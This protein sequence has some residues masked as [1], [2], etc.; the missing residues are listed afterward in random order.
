MNSS[1]FEETSISNR[2]SFKERAKLPENVKFP[3]WLLCPHCARRIPIMRIFYFN[4]ELSPI[5]ISLKCKCSENPMV[6]TL[7]KYIDICRDKFRER[8]LY[9]KGYCVHCGVMLESIKAKI[10]EKMILATKHLLLNREVELKMFCEDEKH[11]DSK[12]I[13]KAF[14]PR[15]NKVICKYCYNMIKEEYEM[16]KNGK[17][18][19]S[20]RLLKFS[21]LRKKV[22]EVLIHYDSVKGYFSNSTDVIELIDILEK[23]YYKLLLNEILEPNIAI[24]L[25]NLF[26]M[27]SDTE[28]K[29]LPNIF[30]DVILTSKFNFSI[31]MNNK[32]YLPLISDIVIIDKS[33]FILCYESFDSVT[34]RE[35]GRRLEVPY[36]MIQMNEEEDL[37]NV[38]SNNSHSSFRK[39][40]KYQNDK[41]IGIKFEVDDRN[42]FTHS[43][44]LFSTEDEDDEPIQSE[45]KDYY[46]SCLCVYKDHIFTGG[47]QLDVWKICKNS[48]NYCSTVRVEED[49][50]K[51][52]SIIQMNFEDFEIGKKKSFES[53]GSMKITFSMEYKIICGTDKGWLLFVKPSTYTIEQQKELNLFKDKNGKKEHSITCMCAVKSRVVATGGKDGL[54]IIYNYEEI[55]HF[56]TIL[57]GHTMEIVSIEKIPSANEIIS[58]A[59]DKQI[60]IW[61]IESQTKLN[62]FT[63]FTPH[64]EKYLLDSFSLFVENC[65]MYFYVGYNNKEGDNVLEIWKSRMFDNERDKNELGL[66]VQNVVIKSNYY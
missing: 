15:E 7:K 30:F 27:L 8:V 20:N 11:K 58:A 25:I 10:H 44:V 1:I 23:M 6:T 9:K 17:I 5:M 52:T 38:I 43:L 13:A 32:M 63:P 50:G 14:N 21:D 2:S 3:F 39:V 4:A 33:N 64:L 41:F 57:Y 18:N 28:M 31:Q 37:L 35:E 56:A 49:K 61:N 40:I 54:I 51:I 45:E 36:R 19:S 34:K 66:M 47:S 12:I 48:I 24:S 59:K 62:V 26:S 55:G 42:K 60:I 65:T 29:P 16:Q 22:D 53:R 46:M